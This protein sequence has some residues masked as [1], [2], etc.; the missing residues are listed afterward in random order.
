MNALSNGITIEVESTG[1]KFHTLD[2]WGF[3][4]GNNNYIGDP[5][6]ET[7][8]ISIPGRDGML[9]ISEAVTGRTT[10]K[11]R[12]LSFLLGGIRH[13]ESWDSVISELRNQV[14][15]RMCKIII[16]ND[17]TFYWRGRTYIVGFDRMRELGQFTLSIPEADPYKY[18]VE[19]SNEPWKW[20]PFNFITGIITNIGAQ[21]IDGSGYVIIPSGYMPVTPEFEVNNMTS[22]DFYVAYKGKTYQLNAGITRIP[23]ILIN[24][25][26]EVEL[27]FTGTADVTIIYRGGSL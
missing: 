4:L 8:Y 11:K 12:E 21:H 6:P 10:Y 25:D 1:K 17:K 22:S 14:N 23:P 7:K 2:D 20:D 16:D 3:A 13:V 9:D 15:G 19:S 24:G 18:N 5:E 27:E 26:E